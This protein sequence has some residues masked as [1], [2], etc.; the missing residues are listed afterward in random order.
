MNYLLTDFRYAWCIARR[1]PG[2]TFAIVVML[3]LGTGGVSAVFIPVYSLISASLPFSEPEQL[4]RIGGNVPIFNTYNSRF[5][6]RDEFDKIFS[7]L[8]AYKSDLSPS[9]HIPETGKYRHNIRFAFV[10]GEFFETLGFRPIRGNTFNRDNEKDGIVISYRI[11]QDEF[12]RADDVVGKIIQVGNTHNTIVGIMPENFDFPVGTDYWWC[13]DGR[14]WPVGTEADQ[15]LG[16]L[17]PGM[18]IVQA[19]KELVALKFDPK[20]G[21]IGNDGLMLQPLKI[22][23]YG[24]RVPLLLALGTVTVLFL[25]LVCTGV[26]NLL[27]TQGVCRRYEMALRLI[28]GATRRNLIFKLLRETLPLV[29]LG[30]LTGLWI[31]EIVNSWLMTRFPTLP[32]GDIAISAKMTFFVMLVFAVTIIGGLIPSLY[33]TNVDLNTCMKSDATFKRSFFSLQELLSGV[34]L[35]LA[36]ALLIG[37]G[38]LLRNIMFNFNIPIGW[39][40]NEIAVVMTQF[41]FPSDVGIITV[42]PDDVR[43]D[44]RFSQEFRH[45]LNTIPGVVVAGALEPIPFSIE[46]EMITT[47][48][49]INVHKNWPTGQSAY[50]MGTILISVS[51]EGFRILGIP[52]IAGRFFTEADVENRLEREIYFMENRR[53]SEIGV[54]AIINQSL[55]RQFWPG[56]N[57]VGKTIYQS[58]GQLVIPY[59]IVGVVQDFYMGGNN[60]KLI[61]TLFVPHIGEVSSTFS[62]RFL[63]RLHSALLMS[64]LRQRLSA[65]DTDSVRIEVQSLKDYTYDPKANTN[66]ALQFL[67][68]FALLGIVV[69]GSGV[70][71]TTT[72]MAS[73]RN[74]EIG[75]RMAM[76]AQTGNIIR[77]VL[78]RGLRPIIIG[79]P[80]GLLLAS[81][82][83]KFLAS[84]IVQ[85]NITDPLAWILS[86]MVLFGIAAIASLIPAL[87]IIRVNPLDVL[88]KE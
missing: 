33:A 42:K 49:Q 9:I 52:L 21:V 20:N 88:R 7:N 14:R 87:R 72:L 3:A 63:V 18:L 1:S 67:G 51:P 6:R 77:F 41:P 56:D 45:N 11:W 55:A 29:V 82:L 28:H 36:L 43:R 53:F 86:C 17:R 35:A 19:M 68:C 73:S 60:K 48:R 5:E 44:A 84:F 26:M 38:L 85:L 22:I 62:L 79:L 83:S 23:L 50:A 25:L 40:S 65:F 66:M 24:D 16:R 4:V 39:S 12:S 31:S 32:D 81:I 46:S 54:P 57:A 2:V 78:W 30:A 37:M 74:K 76:G 75:I 71:A 13:I 34:Q 15:L 58:F 64:D 61:P 59:A 27:V 47:Q 10:S 80:I 69:A 8:T 70:Y